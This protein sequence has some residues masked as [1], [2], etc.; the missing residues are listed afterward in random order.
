MHD[1][2]PNARDYA[3]A[4]RVLRHLGN[5]GEPYAANALPMAQ[6]VARRRVQAEFEFTDEEV[7]Q[8]AADLCSEL[9]IYVD[10]SKRGM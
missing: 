2:K 10:D 7:E 9:G 4:Y 8:A 6:A 3:L 5:G 1:A